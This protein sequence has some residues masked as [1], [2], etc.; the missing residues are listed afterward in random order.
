MNYIVSDIFVI[1]AFDVSYV[2]ESPAISSIA[3][4]IDVYETNMRVKMK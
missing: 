1:S 3:M 4:H 2:V